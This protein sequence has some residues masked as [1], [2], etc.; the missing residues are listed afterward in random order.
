MATRLRVFISS[1]GDVRDAREVAAQTVEKIAPDY[2]RH[3][4]IEPYM[5]ETE[6]LDASGHF[7]DSIEPPS[8]FDIVAMILWSRLGTLLPEETPV[9]RYAGIDGR[10]P[11][12]GT[13]W[14]YEDALRAAR[15][16]GAPSLLVYRSRKSAQVDAW[17]AERR[18]EELE[19]LAALDRFWSRHFA[20]HGTFIGAYHEFADLD[21]L[22]AMFEAHLRKLVDRRVEAATSSPAGGAP[23]ARLWAKSPFRGLEAFEFEH[24]PIFF[25]RAEP[26]GKALG[27]FIDN[28]A[29]GKTFLLVLGA[30]GAG[31]SSIVKAG[32]APR[33]C[34]PRRVVGKSFLRRVTFH[35][36]ETQAG[37]D[38]FASLARAL[39]TTDGDDVGVPGL[40]D[41]EA[42]ARILRAT[43]DHSHAYLEV[44]LDRLTEQARKS[45]RILLSEQAALLLMVDQ[46]EELFTDQRITADQRRG[47]AAL[48]SALSKGG[49][50]WIIATMRSD[51]WHRVSETPDL[52]DLAEGFGRFDA[53]PPRPAEICQMIELPAEAA[54]LT[55]ARNPVD[56]VALDD[57]IVE[58]ASNAPGV[59]P[60]LSYLLEQLYEADAVDAGG[61]VL[62]YA[63]YAKLGGLKGAIA[64]RA[65]TILGAQTDE[66]KA[67]L[68]SMLFS[69][70]Q[71]SADSAGN[72]TMTARRAP[73]ATFVPG[74]PVRTL[75]DAFLD[76]SARLLV[77]DQASEGG[78][79]VRVAH[80][81][82][83]T[84]WRRAKDC[85]G[86]DAVLLAIRRTTE[87]RYAR[88]T[89]IAP[90][91][92]GP[93]DRV[94]AAEPGLLSGV[95]LDEARRLD[96]EF[97]GDLP[98]GIV[99]YIERSAQSE[100]RRRRRV[101][102]VLSSIAAATTLLAAFAGAMAYL[103]HQ[104]A[105]AALV[106]LTD[107]TLVDSERD[108]DA[109]V[110][111]RDFTGAIAKY[112][113]NIGL[114]QTL[115]S[116]EPANPQWLF[117]LATEHAR[118]GY[119]LLRRGGP[120]DPQRAHEEFLAAQATAESVAKID[121]SSTVRAD[122]I[123]F[124]K[125]LQKYLSP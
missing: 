69:L 74:T 103:A 118:L 101:V 37:E 114:A 88:W 79:V 18:N 90:S 42:L 64:A 10:V 48:L 125:Q 33:L 47:F 51:L 70:V 39:A 104:S 15:D 9:R 21:N 97:R 23:G 99:Q 119:V 112:T 14:E 52:I 36:S 22:A 65:E 17:D 35:P 54:G 3:F 82:L 93:L 58:D 66:V 28:A 41:V 78:P 49:R 11:V 63:T 80:E 24:A 67:A 87:E 83:L 43:P 75:V 113:A 108:G 62:T 122:R 19:Q 8:G 55:F 7:Q 68:R 77:A 30:S 4:A 72:V 60:L 6:A 5:W 94:L 38:V 85:I 31:K 91:R 121:G 40:D 92:A 110:K 57:Q 109:D 117:N 81:A 44:A 84:E 13:E 98:A 59:L 1:P 76:P 53:L 124:Q 86:D 56:G 107:R 116:R 115:V 106:Q 111:A 29:A 25:G 123:A 89:A 100:R 20:D 27:Q 26:V 16:H 61:S 95:D 12:T 46:L 73:L 105:S 50:V 120:G 45:G 96:R 34:L 71:T 2:L 102:V 32:M